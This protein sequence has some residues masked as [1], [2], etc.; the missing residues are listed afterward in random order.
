[1]LPEYTSPLDPSSQVDVVITHQDED[2][3]PNIE[4]VEANVSFAQVTASLS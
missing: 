4:A 1:M 2:M 3:Y